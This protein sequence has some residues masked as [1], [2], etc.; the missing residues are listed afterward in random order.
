MTVIL[1]STPLNLADMFN[2]DNREWQVI[3]IPTDPGL[4][5]NLL[6]FT[7]RSGILEKEFYM[8]VN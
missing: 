3:T 6:K 8:Q 4:R 1:R 7:A 5:G 2:Y